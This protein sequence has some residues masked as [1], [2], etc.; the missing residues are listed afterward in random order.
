RRT[1]KALVEDLGIEPSP[2]LRRLET[3]ILVQEPALELPRAGVFGVGSRVAGSA[4]ATAR[5]DGQ[6]PFVGREFELAHLHQAFQA[7]RALKTAHLITVIG[8]PG[9]G[10]TRLA[11]EFLAATRG[12]AVGLVAGCPRQG[13]G[14]GSWPLAAIVRQLAGDLSP[15]A[16]ERVAASDPDSAKIAAWLA[17]SLGGGRQHADEEETLWAARKLFEAVGRRQ[18]AIVVF[19]DVQ[20]AEESLLS[21]VDNLSDWMRN[22]PLLLI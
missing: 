6:T 2:A 19:D 1:R 16:I 20:W 12:S 18:P 17:G 13:E 14:A 10:K 5:S 21:Y 22:V 8:A 9:V 11:Y 7:T 3:A 4:S 15:A